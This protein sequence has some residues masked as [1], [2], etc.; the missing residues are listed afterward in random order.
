LAAL[1]SLVT[2]KFLSDPAALLARKKE[3]RVTF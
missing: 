1:E 2:A 3:D